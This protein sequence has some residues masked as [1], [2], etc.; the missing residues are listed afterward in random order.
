MIGMFVFGYLFVLEQILDHLSMIENKN[1]SELES[2]LRRVVKHSSSLSG[3]KSD[4]GTEKGTV[5]PVCSV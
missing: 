5:R 1:E 4:R 3:F 2:H